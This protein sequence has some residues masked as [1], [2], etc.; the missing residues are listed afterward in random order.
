MNADPDDIEELVRELRADLPSERDSARVR[1]RLGGLGVGLGA[2]LS[3]SAAA[4]SAGAKASAGATGIWSQVAALSWGAK[5]G[6]AAAVSLPAATSPL[7]LPEVRSS[8]TTT[9]VASASRAK[10]TTDVASATAGRDRGSTREQAATPA[11]VEPAVHDAVA[12]EVAPTLGV[13]PEVGN[14]VEP[15]LA[16]SG[17]TGSRSPA[18]MARNQPATAAL[19]GRVAAREEPATMQL[20]TA[21]A[22]GHLPGSTGLPESSDTGPIV[23][24]TGSVAPVSPA[25]T[26][27]SGT[28]DGVAAPSTASGVAQSPSPAPASSLSTLGE[29]TALMDAALAALRAGDLP[30]AARYVHAHE[31]RF[32]NGL[33]KRE[34][35]RARRTVLE[36]S[37]SGR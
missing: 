7:W 15:D 33:L 12:P 6:L 31:L 19:N 20:G 4:A 11:N 1:A 14:G 23:G 2:V 32:P 35:E 34:R 18:A 30:T 37:R 24:A 17:R 29:E 13:A 22:N 10:L 27:T 25:V 26:A 8:A 3:G 5:V 16:A 21:S 36:R 28:N 9:T